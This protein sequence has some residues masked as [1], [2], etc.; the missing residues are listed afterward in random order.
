MPKLI[1]PKKEAGGVADAMEDAGFDQL[2]IH[3]IQAT[4][5]QL[6]RRTALE[7]MVMTVSNQRGTTFHELVD[8]HPQWEK[9][10][11][12]PKKAV[13]KK[14]VKKAVKKTAKKA[15]KRN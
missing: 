15:V 8:I 4:C 14:P 3:E 10:E 7:N 2:F 11:P 13:A 6:W 1:D 12:T 5:F 9:P